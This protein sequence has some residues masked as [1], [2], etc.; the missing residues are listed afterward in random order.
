MNSDL[1]K[2]WVGDKKISSSII[3]AIALYFAAKYAKT[4]QS[5]NLPSMLGGATIP[6]FVLGGVIGLS[7][8][9]FV[10]AFSDIILPHIPL[11]EKYKKTE[12]IVVHILLGGS[13][14]VL[15]PKI[16][17][18]ISG[19]GARLDNN[20]LAMFAGAGVATEVISQLLSTWLVKESSNGAIIVK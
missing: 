9:F 13:A 11:S 3:G 20:K 6:V 16:L 19:E 4:S 10:D 14:F 8:S 2:N 18:S 1:L 15:I 12:S 7:S 17:Y 5:V